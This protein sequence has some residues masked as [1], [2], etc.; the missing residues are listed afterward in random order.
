M[1]KGSSMIKNLLKISS[2]LITTSLFLVLFLGCEDDA[3]LE[4]QA[5]TGSDGGSYGLLLLEN[6]SDLDEFE[7]NPEIF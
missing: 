1:E 2:F 7:E 6:D 3:I 5:D 4:P